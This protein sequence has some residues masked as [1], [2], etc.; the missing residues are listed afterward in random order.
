MC[1]VHSS[2]RI[3]CRG[4]RE[5]NEKPCKE[6]PC[7]RFLPQGG[8]NLQKCLKFAR[9][10]VIM[11]YRRR[12]GCAHEEHDG[13][14]KKHRKRGRHRADGGSQVSQQPLLDLSV[15]SPRI[16][17]AQ[18]EKIRSTVRRYITRGHVDVFLAYTDKTERRRRRSPWIRGSRGRIGRRRRL[19]KRRCPG[20]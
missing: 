4:P 13:I 11:G 5:P 12:G 19:L 15:K 18:E 9:A 14:R 2:R 20:W 3:W 1:I 16:F 6:S 7:G 10:R 17:L 8:K